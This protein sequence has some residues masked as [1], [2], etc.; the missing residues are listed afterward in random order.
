MAV[1]NGNMGD[2]G[3]PYDSAGSSKAEHQIVGIWT[4]EEGA[5]NR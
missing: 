3:A 5:A 1:V 4:N 2:T